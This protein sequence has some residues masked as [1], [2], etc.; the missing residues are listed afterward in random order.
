M[1][2][3]LPG[4]TVH[5]ILQARI[6]EWVV[7]SSSRGSFQLRDRISISWVSCTAGWFFTTE[8]LGK[9]HTTLHTTPHTGEVPHYPPL[10]VTHW[11][12]HG[13]LHFLSCSSDT[14]LP[15]LENVP[16]FNSSQIILIWIMCLLILADSSFSS[17]HF[18]L[19]TAPWTEYYFH[20]TY[21]AT[22]A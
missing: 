12:S 8:P 10:A 7:I 11:S 2:C 21:D 15:L 20:L 4:S 19:T 16:L 13:R 14:L 5:G 9:S 3:S 18:I 6:L 22:E 17:H 1:D